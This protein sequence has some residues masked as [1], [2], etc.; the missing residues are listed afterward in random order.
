MEQ[1]I[2]VAM[3]K[4]YDSTNN[5]LIGMNT[6]SCMAA[7]WKRW[8]MTY[9]RSCSLYSLRL[10]T[11]LNVTDMIGT[12]WYSLGLEFNLLVLLRIVSISTKGII[13]QALN[14]A[15][16]QSKAIVLAAVYLAERC[17][18]YLASILRNSKQKLTINDIFNIII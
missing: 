18:E 1:N 14:S 2:Y 4:N 7:N 12:D 16:S 15:D 13:L 8:L 6:L 10:Y 17:I 11:T 5:F 9:S 3:S